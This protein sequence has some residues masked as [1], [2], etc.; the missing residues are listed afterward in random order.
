MHIV[1][2][3]NCQNFSVVKSST[4]DW[5][6]NYTC[7]IYTCFFIHVL[8]IHVCF[9]HVLFIHVFFIHVIFLYVFVIH[10]IFI[11]AFFIHVIFM[12]IFFIHMLFLHIFFIHV[13]FLHVFLPLPFQD[14]LWRHGGG[15]S[16]EPEENDGL[17]WTRLGYRAG[18]GGGDET[19][20]DRVNLL[21]FRSS[22]SIVS[23]LPKYL[24]YIARS[25]WSIVL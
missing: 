3:N 18:Y 13:L 20:G 9:K 24:L 7:F 23:K 8:S 11:H 25:Y 16:H 14:R 1:E 6:K 15:A 19:R 4:S 21:K 2:W 10:V 22:C 12:H 17:G 5:A